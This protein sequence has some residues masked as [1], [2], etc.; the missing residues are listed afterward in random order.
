MTSAGVW[1]SISAENNYLAFEV[2]IFQG[3]TY[4]SGLVNND[5]HDCALMKYDGTTYTTFDLI[6]GVDLKVCMAL[7]QGKLW[8]ASTGTLSSF[9]GSSLTIPEVD[10]STTG[11]DQHF[12]EVH[13]LEAVGDSLA[14]MV[15][16]TIA[17]HYNILRSPGADFGGV[18]L[19]DFIDTLDEADS[20]PTLERL[21]A[22]VGV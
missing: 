4:I 2:A 10:F 21:R 20:P 11:Q 3:A 12:G 5:T 19:L 15:E 17:G 8:F 7:A 16:G 18:W 6:G 22:L 1:S 9:D 14:M 13:G